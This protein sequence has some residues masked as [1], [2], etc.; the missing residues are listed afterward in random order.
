MSDQNNLTIVIPTRNRPYLVKN[1]VKFYNSVRFSF[2]ILYIDGSDVEIHEENLRNIAAYGQ[3][4][5]CKIARAKPNE[6]VNPARRINEQFRDHLDSIETEFVCQSGDDDFYLESGIRQQIQRLRERH[7]LSACG[8]IYLHV[9]TRN[10]ASPN[11]NSREGHLS[12]WPAAH[13]MS[14]NA[15]ERIRNNVTTPFN[16]SY[17]VKRTKIWKDC[18]SH[19]SENE[20]ESAHIEQLMSAVVLARGKV[21]R[22]PTISLIRHYHHRNDDSMRL[23]ETYNVFNP[24]FERRANLFLDNFRT[25]F[26]L[27][28]LDVPKDWRKQLIIGFRICALH[29]T[30]VQLRRVTRDW[31]QSGDKDKIETETKEVLRKYGDSTLI[32]NIVEFIVDNTLNGLN[33]QEANSFVPGVTRFG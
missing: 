22:I 18:F 25:L 15:F 13:R 30:S 12:I 33:G 1:Q 16:V 29:D 28:D 32:Q 24:D 6:F 9:M 14:S 2:K 8:G 21:E 17:A 4:I 23:D 3:N 10:L 31:I 27:Y 20:M 5:D 26:D 7:D 11:L 19:F